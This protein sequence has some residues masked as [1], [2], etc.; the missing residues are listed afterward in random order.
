MHTLTKENELI[1]PDAVIR[2]LVRLGWTQEQIA[3]EVDTTQATINRIYVGKHQQ[4]RY[5]LVDRLRA[6]Y[7]SVE[8]FSQE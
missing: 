1:R 3:L 2:K 8:D 4:P 5:M 7:Q 6:L